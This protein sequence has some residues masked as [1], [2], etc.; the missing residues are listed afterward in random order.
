MKD[1][2]TKLEAIHNAL[3]TIHNGSDC[4][5]HE[6]VTALSHLW[7]AAVQLG[8]KRM[9]DHINKEEIRRETATELL[10][11]LI[12]SETRGYSLKELGEKAISATD[13]FLDKV[14]IPF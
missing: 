14:K 9:D 5:Q 13:D 7:D 10:V 4:Y 3:K 12:K 11:A 2:D 6:D 8:I 1:D